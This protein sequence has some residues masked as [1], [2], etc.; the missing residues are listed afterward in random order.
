MI[1]LDRHIQEAT[2]SAVPR[3][4]WPA[5]QLWL[6]LFPLLTESV[7]FLQVC[8]LADAASRA[9][10]H[11]HRMY[12]REEFNLRH[13]T[14]DEYLLERHVPPPIH[15]FLTDPVWNDHPPQT[16]RVWF[17]SMREVV[18][19]TFIVEERGYP[20]W[21]ADRFEAFYH[22]AGRPGR[23][24][25]RRSHHSGGRGGPRVSHRKSAA[26]SQR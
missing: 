15:A 17:P 21:T 13:A 4:R 14:I 8:Q 19:L 24:H 10:S 11:Q 16:G 9:L 12:Y 1:R 2:T 20:V 22:Q 7:G 3:P 5:S 23:S 6:G 26:P 25:E 18:F